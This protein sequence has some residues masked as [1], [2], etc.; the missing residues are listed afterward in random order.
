[1]TDIKDDIQLINVFSK[2]FYNKTNIIT[3]RIEDTLFKLDKIIEEENKNEVFLNDLEK[4][5]CDDELTKI[6]KLLCNYKLNLNDKLNEYTYI[7][8]INTK[9]INNISN[10]IKNNKDIIDNIY[11]I[12]NILDENT[13][14]IES[15]INK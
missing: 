14:N 8:D 15:K 9:K 7:V 3:N 6:L 5:V 1:M 11:K 10:N 13:S 2:D 12:V 4:K